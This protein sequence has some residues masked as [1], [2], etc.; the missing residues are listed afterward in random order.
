MKF[1]KKD[2]YKIMIFSLLIIFL[3][4]IFLVTQKHEF[5]NTDFN[6][7]NLFSKLILE[8]ST[9]HYDNPLNNRFN[10]PIFGI[11]GLMNFGSNKLLSSTV[12][13]GVVIVYALFG[14]I[15]KNLTNLI[16]PL[17]ILLSLLF[18][19]LI[20]KKFIFKDRGVLTFI[21]LILF[22]LS[23]SFIY[24]S[25][26]PFK[27]IIATSIFLASLYYSFKVI[28]NNQNNDL[29]LF[30]ILLSV[31]IWL[32]YV[33]VIFFLPSFIFAIYKWKFEIFNIKKILI[34]IIPFL[35]V[36]IPLVL[37][38]INYTGG[39]LKF[40]S[41]DFVLN[42]NN[43]ESN[44][45]GIFS[46][47]LS[48][49]TD[50]L[51]HNFLNQIVFLSPIIAITFLLSLPLLLIVRDKKFNIYLSILLFII[52][53]QF[54][55]FLTKSWSGEGFIGSSGTSYVRYLLVSWGFIF[56]LSVFTLSKL[57]KNKKSL[58]IIIMLIL[59][60]GIISGIY[61]EMSIDY[62]IETSS[63][64]NSFKEKI[65]ENTPEGAI[66]FSGYNDKYIYPVRTIAIYPA[67]PKDIRVNYTTEMI[68][69]LCAEGEDI[70]FTRE[71]PPSELGF[72]FEEYKKAFLEK[73]IM[74]NHKF[75]SLYEISCP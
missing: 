15:S 22:S 68:D 62:F 12:I 2:Y 18:F 75:D 63:W 48:F 50:K 61:S 47:L 57:I 59:C 54:M 60:G 19:Y 58:L 41:P 72:S 35:I 28:K 5:P 10:Y 13:P 52:L 69:S 7:I 65:V 23:A 71:N 26:T 38:Q 67:I 39:F 43:P 64:T 21:T 36:F 74:L 70:Y 3:I 27:D 29:I 20:L 45:R 56:T 24:V 4:A 66:I 8:E 55:F 1:I 9:M 34:F 40:N 49:N 33:S 14:G 53:L 30:S 31:S 51:Y 25:G 17:F 46:F 37:Y 16:N 32:N 6:Q 42:Y 73:G 44:P 11:R